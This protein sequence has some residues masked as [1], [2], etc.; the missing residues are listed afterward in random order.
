V[1]EYRSFR[2]TDPPFLVELWN[3]SP[4][5]RGAILLRSA[6]LLERFVFC[7]PYFDPAGLIVAEE[8]GHVIGFAHAGG[9]ASADGGEAD[10][11]ICAI[12]VAPAHRR[13]G[14]GTQLLYR[15]EEYLLQLGARHLYAGPHPP[16]NPFYT[17]LYGGADTPGFF[18][19]DG[20]AEPFFR[21]HRYQVHD[22]ILVLQRKLNQP[23]K[24]PDPR[25][26]DLRQR[27][28]VMIGSPRSL[29]GWWDECT[30]GCLEPL[31]I[32]LQDRDKKTIAG[33]VLL[34]EM[35]AFSQQW[36]KPAIGILHFNIHDDYRGQGLG[37]LLLTQ[38]LRQMQEQF[39]ELI[40][41]QISEKNLVAMSLLRQLNFE[42]VDRG[43]VFVKQS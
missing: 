24:T 43:Q 3:A 12:A 42:S 6:T 1:V 11:V 14:I 38:L 33:R 18:K 28:D 5:G 27:F 4:P 39:F 22:V 8:E 35:E 21:R 2:N 16:L 40:E 7:K 30:L 36:G 32:V 37:K 15:C 20:H 10:G 25:F 9:C 19:S 41:I 31:E 17:G 26:A 34:W 23:L 13:R 29:G